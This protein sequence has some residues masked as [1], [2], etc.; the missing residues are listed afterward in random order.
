MAASL[1]IEEE[2]GACAGHYHPHT[3]YYAGD[4]TNRGTW[5][6]S[7]VAHHGRHGA[8]LLRPPGDDGGQVS[9]ASRHHVLT[10]ALAASDV[11]SLT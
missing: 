6:S 9:G 2:Q 7:A 10:S 4:F 3:G 5:P 1:A 8:V 11:T